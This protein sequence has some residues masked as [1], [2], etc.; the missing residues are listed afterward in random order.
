MQW[1]RMLSCECGWGRDRAV[2]NAVLL[3]L[4]QLLSEADRRLPPPMTRLARLAFQRAVLA[5]CEALRRAESLTGA[6]ARYVL[7]QDGTTIRLVF[8]NERS[9]IVYD[10]VQDVDRVARTLPAQGAPFEF[11]PIRFAERDQLRGLT[12]VMN[13][14]TVIYRPHRVIEVPERTRAILRR[15]CIPYQIARPR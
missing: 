9:R 6:E 3:L 11:R 2:Q 13:A 5:W 15:L 14:G 7:R 10:T 12:A 8:A 1:R 4:T